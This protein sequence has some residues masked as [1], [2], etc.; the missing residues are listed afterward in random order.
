M[1]HPSRPNNH[2]AKWRKAERIL[3]IGE[4]KSGFFKPQSAPVNPPEQSDSPFPSP[5]IKRPTNMNP[6]TL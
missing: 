1:A 5:S 4:F 6:P 2:I 3:A